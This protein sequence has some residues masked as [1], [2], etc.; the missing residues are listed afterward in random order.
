[1]LRGPQPLP[2]LFSH[3]LQSAHPHCAVAAEIKLGAGRGSSQDAAAALSKGLVR[4]QP[5]QIAGGR[6]GSES[7]H[8]TTERRFPMIHY[9]IFV[10]QKVNITAP[11]LAG[12]VEEQI[13]PARKARLGPQTTALR[14]H[15][16]RSY[17]LLKFLKA[18][19][20]LC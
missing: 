15:F 17:H 4:A 2:G 1:M 20:P 7:S 3:S 13:C 11:R 5:R 9:A 18:V 14:P 8:G 6:Q 16:G 12:L 10:A 19:R